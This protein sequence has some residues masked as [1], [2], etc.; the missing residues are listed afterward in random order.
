[1]PSLDRRSLI[2]GL[3]VCVSLVGVLGEALAD[4]VTDWNGILLDAVRAEKTAPPRA[5]RA[6]A[7]VNVSTFEAVNGILGLYEPYHLTD[8]AQ[9]GTSPEAAAAAAAHR[10]LC[11]LFPAQRNVFDAAL[12]ASL[13]AI[14]DGPPRRA[15]VS[16][17]QKVADAIMAL[18]GDDGSTSEVNHRYRSG[19]G[20]WTPTPPDFARG[21]LPNWVAVKP[22]AMASC[23]QFRPPPPPSLGSAEYLEAFSE[24][25]R[26]GRIDSPW[27]STEQS[28]IVLFWADGP[29]TGTPPGHWLIVALNL[30]AQRSLSLHENSRLMALLSMALADGAVVSWDSKYHYDHWRP[31]TGIQHAE[32]NGDRGTRVAA[33]WMPFISTPPFPSYTSGHSTFSGAA[34]RILERFFGTDAVRFSLVSDGLPGVERFYARFSQAAEEA[35]Q[36]R[37]YGGIHWQYDNQAGL[38][39]GRALGDHVFSTRLHPRSGGARSLA[40]RTK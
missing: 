5:S 18:R 23:S 17:G 6:M 29:G 1:M 26:L 12:K 32:R 30:A 39:S 21:L 22:W 40:G 27:R 31:V 33:A 37:I 34:S 15:G 3:A 10:S 35:G 38:A 11:D 24:V 9:P 14:P 25:A 20:W 13:A 28:Q 36:S 16:W 7:C 8:T 19:D 2:V 4:V